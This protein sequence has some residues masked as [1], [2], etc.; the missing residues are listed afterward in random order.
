MT[1][2]ATSPR[3]FTATA[4]YLRLEVPRTLRNRRLI[5]LTIVFPV[6]FYLLFTRVLTG[7]AQLDNDARAFLMV[8][9]AVYGAIGAALSSAVRVAME[10]TNG[11][12]RQLRVTPL[13]P[14]GYVTTKLAV[15][16]VTALPAILLTMLAALTVNQVVLSPTTWVAVFVV[17]GLGVLPFAALGVAIGYV[18]DES[19]AQLV[20]SI[21]FVG[22]SVLGGL[23]TPISTF[24]D[25]VA[26]IGRMLPSFHFANL[27]WSV[28][29]GQAPDLGDVMALL[30]Y[31]L[32]FAGIV[33]WRYRVGEQ[34]A[35]G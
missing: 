12:T 7:W 16:Y 27:G 6:A 35:R 33:A 9:M 30:A 3:S 11:W 26:T 23:W 1:A 8:S 34:K 22:L 31:L 17:L 29:A 10:R 13:P 2:L 32:V 15:A 19:T 18:F 5:V 4:A 14:F 24:P 28:L 25:A 20:F 21:S